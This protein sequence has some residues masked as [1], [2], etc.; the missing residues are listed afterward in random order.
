VALDISSAWSHISNHRWTAGA[1]VVT[2]PGVLRVHQIPFSTNVDRLALAARIKGVAIEY[3]DH[4]SDDRTAIR[5]LSGQDLVPVVEVDG[6]VLFDSPVILRWLDAEYPD[7]PLW[8]ADPALQARVDVVVEWFNG[9]WKGPPNWLTDDPDNP[10]REQWAAQLR[11]WTDTIEG[12]LSDGGYLVGES[13]TAADVIAYP[14]LRYGVDAPEPTDTHPFHHIIHRHCALG[15]Q[16][17]A[18]RAWVERMR[19]L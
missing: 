18:T 16:H 17:A 5:A 4:D 6:K 7:P 19:E 10:A 13:V 14:F 2:V 3:V 8:P 15:P 1:R 12:L 11:G 9:V